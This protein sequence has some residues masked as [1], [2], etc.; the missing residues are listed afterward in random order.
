MKSI[1][2]NPT[3]VVPKINY[4]CLMVSNMTGC[5]VLFSSK[6]CGTVVSL[7]DIKPCYNK[8]GDESDGWVSNNFTLYG[9]TVTLSN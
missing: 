2:A 7:G 3:P 1:K 4:P 6:S 8:I 9:G 5:I